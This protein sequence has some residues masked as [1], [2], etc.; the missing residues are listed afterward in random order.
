M[1]QKLHLEQQFEA[2]EKIALQTDKSFIGAVYAQ[3]TKQ[4]KGLEHL[5]KRLLKAQKRKFS[6]ELTQ[7][8]SIQHEL[9]PN[10]SLQE[11]QLNFSEFYI[12]NGTP[13]LKKIVGELKPLSQKFTI[14]KV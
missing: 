1:S 5:E 4:I 7:I 14:I 12:E 2:L 10:H 3:K 9:F 13:I 8:V 6:E 11:R